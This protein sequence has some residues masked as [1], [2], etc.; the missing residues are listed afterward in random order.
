MDKQDTS[1]KG[2]AKVLIIG[3]VN[4]G[5]AKLIND[6]I[7][8]LQKERPSE[9][10]TNPVFDITTTKKVIETKEDIHIE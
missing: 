10:D 2:C 6:I 1:S 7:E 4:G 5:R 8:N 3:H 9:L